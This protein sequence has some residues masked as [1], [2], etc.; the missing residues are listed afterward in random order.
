MLD[1]GAPKHEVA[2]GFGM[3]INKLNRILAQYG[4]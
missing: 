1:A 4:D 2:G 3:G